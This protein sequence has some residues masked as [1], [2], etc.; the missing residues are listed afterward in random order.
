MTLRSTLRR[1]WRYSVTRAVYR[2]LRQAGNGKVQSAWKSLGWVCG[3]G[4]IY[5][6]DVWGWGRWRW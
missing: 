4:A 2:G 5:D 3:C 6:R 1:R